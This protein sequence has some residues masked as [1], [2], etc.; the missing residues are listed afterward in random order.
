MPARSLSHL[1]V[2]KGQ[3]AET[4]N[5]EVIPYLRE[6]GRQVAELAQALE[7]LEARVAALETL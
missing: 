3:E 6:L 2:A 5:R 7:D 1:P 4:L